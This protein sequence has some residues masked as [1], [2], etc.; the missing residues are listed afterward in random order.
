M[1]TRPML[2]GIYRYLDLTPFLGDPPQKHKVRILLHSHVQ[3]TIV[4]FSVVFACV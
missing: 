2:P 1:P 3:E 4:D